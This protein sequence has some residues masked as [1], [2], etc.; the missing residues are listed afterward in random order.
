MLFFLKKK[1]NSSKNQWEEGVGGDILR[2]L[3][4]EFNQMHR[5]ECDI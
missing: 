1:K 3:L 5:E 2:G 4:E